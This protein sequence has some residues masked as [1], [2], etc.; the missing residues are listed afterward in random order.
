MSAVRGG[1]MQVTDL[2]SRMEILACGWSFVRRG[3][4]LSR[5]KWKVAEAGWG[6]ASADRVRGAGDATTNQPCWLNRA[7]RCA[8]GATSPVIIRRGRDIRTAPPATGE[9]PPGIPGGREG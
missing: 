2:V 5:A 8:Y 7:A 3:P 1:R 4:K 9:F 6:F